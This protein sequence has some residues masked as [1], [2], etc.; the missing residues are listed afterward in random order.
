MRETVMPTEAHSRRFFEG[1]DAST[2][3]W[4]LGPMRQSHPSF[5]VLEFA[6]GPRSA[7]WNYV[8]VGAI[9]VNPPNSAKLEFLLC[10]AEQMDRGVELVTMTAWYHSRHG[11][12]LGHTMP[13]GEPWVPRAS[14]DHFLISRPYPY[15]PDLEILSI[16]GGHAHL[17]WLL[18][19]TKE[20]RAYKMTHGLEALERLFDSNSIEYWIP[21]RPSVVFDGTG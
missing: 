14:C 12:G 16:E 19:I 8:S 5:H 3:A 21:D 17:L 11:L 13:I 9:D 4:P 18:P 1:H 7:L 20:E 15:G 2:R 10:A 6:P